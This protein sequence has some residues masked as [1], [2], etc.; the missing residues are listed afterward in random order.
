[1]EQKEEV[2]RGNRTYNSEF[3]QESVTY[4]EM[5]NNYLNKRSKRYGK[6]NSD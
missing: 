6:H 5:M 2:S 1:M 4:E 3:P